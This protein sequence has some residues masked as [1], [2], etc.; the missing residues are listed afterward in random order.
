MDNNEK[1]ICEL[2]GE[3]DIGAVSKS[4]LIVAVSKQSRLIRDLVQELFCENPFNLFFAQYTRD[5][6]KPLNDERIRRR[7]GISG[8]SEVIHPVADGR[9][10][11]TKKL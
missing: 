7:V 2:F 10:K 5:E 1:A 3:R 8:K 11:N 6:I 9:H 4:R